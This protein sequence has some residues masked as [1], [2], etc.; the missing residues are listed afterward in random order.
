MPETGGRTGDGIMWYWIL[1][2]EGLIF[3]PLAAIYYWLRHIPFTLKC[4]KCR[5][6]LYDPASLRSGYCEKCHRARLNNMTEFYADEYEDSQ[7]PAR[8]APDNFYP[9]I[10][11]RIKNGTCEKVLDVGCGLGYLLSRLNIPA[12]SRYGIDAG[13]GALKVARSL[14]I[15]GNICLADVRQIPFKSNSFDYLVC[16][17]VLEHFNPEN[18]DAVVRECHRVLK[19]AGTAIFTV[20]N[21]QGV[22]GNYF[23]AHVRFFKFGVITGVLRN[24]GFEIIARQK[25]GLYLP[26]ISRFLG[27]I[28]NAQKRYVP[29]TPM[30][31][32]ELPEFLSMTFL[33]ECR[34]K[35]DVP[36]RY[37]AGKSDYSVSES[38]KSHILTP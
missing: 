30:V 12:E 15:N 1:R 21:G 27:F 6:R 26:F 13:P 18:G 17:E 9:R 8:L 16:T 31:N 19:P 20:P 28:Y 35:A 14:V 38:P 37:R 23:N 7:V 22:M 5:G 32:V 29:V 4:R 2:L 11:N 10:I 3:L 24:A 25:F 33:I 36:D 34:K